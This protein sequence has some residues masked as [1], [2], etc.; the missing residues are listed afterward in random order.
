MRA[1]INK[2]RPGL[3]SFKIREAQNEIEYYSRIF[4]PELKHNTGFSVSERLEMA[5]EKLEQVKNEYILEMPKCQIA[6]Y[7]RSE[8]IESYKTA[9]DFK[10]NPWIKQQNLRKSIEYINDLFAIY[11]ELSIYSKKA[12]VNPKIILTINPKDQ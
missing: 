10:F 1:L 8:A 12:I 4:D 6:N 5:K 3:R 2:H 9:I 7:L 11:P